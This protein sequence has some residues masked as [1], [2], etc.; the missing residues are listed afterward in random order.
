MHSAAFP[1]QTEFATPTRV[2]C[3]LVW[4]WVGRHKYYRSDSKE[5]KCIKYSAINRS[6]ILQLNGWMES[7]K[8]FK[9]MGYINANGDN[10]I[11]PLIQTPC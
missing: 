10:T 1:D 8:W 7:D 11:T 2:R 4:R 3:A 5:D 6:D 9:A